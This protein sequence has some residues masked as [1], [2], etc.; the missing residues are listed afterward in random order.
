MKELWGGCNAVGISLCKKRC[1]DAVGEIQDDDLL[2][3]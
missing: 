1:V 3:V 2:V